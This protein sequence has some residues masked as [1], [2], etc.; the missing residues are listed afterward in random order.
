MHVAAQTPTTIYELIND[1]W[2]L[3]VQKSFAPALSKRSWTAA[4]VCALLT[5]AL[6]PMN[7][8]L[9]KSIS[10][11][12]LAPTLIVSHHLRLDLCKTTP[13]LPRAHHVKRLRLQRNQKLVC[14]S[15]KFGFMSRDHNSFFVLVRVCSFIVR[16]FSSKTGSFARGH[17]SHGPA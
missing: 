6:R 11:S 2:S 12:F 16:L 8:K 1:T 13:H 7:V 14:G 5:R 9:S 4:N 15:S 10:L 17:A 3:V